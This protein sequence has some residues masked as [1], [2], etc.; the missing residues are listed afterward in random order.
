M[1]TTVFRVAEADLRRALAKRATIFVVILFIL[2]LI[3]AI[4]LRYGLE[5]EQHADPS[6]WA[7]IMGV[8]IASTEMQSEALISLAGIASWWWLVVSLYSG[9]LFAADFESGAVRLILARPVTRTE[10]VVGKILSILGLLTVLS[11]LGGLS[12]YAAARIIGGPQEGLVT[13]VGISVVLVLGAIPLLLTGALV[14]GKMG[15][16]T[17]G[18]IVAILIYI[19]VRL[20]AGMVS[21]ALLFTHGGG[22]LVEMS[23]KANSLVPFDGGKTLGVLI[24]SYLKYG[25]VYTPPYTYEVTPEGSPFKIVIGPI[26]VGDILVLNLVSTLTWTILLTLAAVYVIKRKDF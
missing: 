3:A 23:L 14:G 15:K 11:I 1:D 16:A 25:P 22:N 20:V 17:T 13:L 10:Y 5:V 2:P 19:V 18:I 12:I 26:K 9:D 8:D 21:T 24:Y 6:L 7:T 4:A